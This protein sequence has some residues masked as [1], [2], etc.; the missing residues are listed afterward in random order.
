MRSICDSK[1]TSS[2]MP[3]SSL[4]DSLITSDILCGGLDIPKAWLPPP[5]PAVIFVASD[6]LSPA[7][8]NVARCGVAWY[9]VVR[10]GPLVAGVCSSSRDSGRRRQPRFTDLLQV[11]RELILCPRARLDLSPL[12]RH[13]AR[14]FGPSRL[15]L[16]AFAFRRLAFRGHLAVPGPSALPG[17]RVWRKRSVCRPRSQQVSPRKI[18]PDRQ[19]G[20]FTGSAK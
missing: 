4:L 18:D 6:L 3:R 20:D 9:A 1:K 12:L 11:R 2:S 17:L 19:G 13:E 5:P 7:R 16:L 15:R 14:R 8:C 10:C